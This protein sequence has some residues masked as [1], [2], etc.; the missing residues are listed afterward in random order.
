MGFTTS[1]SWASSTWVIFI[2]LV[3]VINGA[4]FWNITFLFLLFGA[5]VVS[6]FPTCIVPLT[7]MYA[8]P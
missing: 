6:L 3:Q 5:A 2:S 7:Y 4:Q 1:I 8:S